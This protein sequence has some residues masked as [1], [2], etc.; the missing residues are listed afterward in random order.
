MYLVHIMLHVNCVVTSN[1]HLY[2][3]YTHTGHKLFFSNFSE[4]RK[5]AS[6][7]FQY[8]IDDLRIYVG[9]C[10]YWIRFVVGWVGLELVV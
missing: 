5:D 8:E 6:L 10:V 2:V 7:L 4:N 1:L 9:L 3:L